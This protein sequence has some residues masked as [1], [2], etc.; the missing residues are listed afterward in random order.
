MSRIGYALIAAAVL[1]GLADAGLRLWTGGSEP[2][3]AVLFL[4]CAAMLV[5]MALLLLS[6]VNRL[7]RR[8]VILRPVDA[9][10]RA[11]IVFFIFLGLRFLLS[12]IFSG[13]MPDPVDAILYAACFS[14]A[15]SLYTT[16]YR[17][18]A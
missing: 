8:E 17:K 18:P 5:G 15:Y 14:A 12:V 9:A 4:F 10:K 3:L 13:T 7:T 6:A 2:S 1:L 11:V 16:A